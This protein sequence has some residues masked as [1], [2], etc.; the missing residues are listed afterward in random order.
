MGGVDLGWWLRRKVELEL[1]EEQS[2]LGLRFGVA[3]Q[4]DDAGIGGGDLHVD[5][6]H[7]GELF[8][9]AARG[10]ARRQGAQAPAQGDV[11]AIESRRVET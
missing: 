3:G 2:E 5:H 4:R 10:E 6:L 9:D 11:Q 8:Q 1:V 7:G